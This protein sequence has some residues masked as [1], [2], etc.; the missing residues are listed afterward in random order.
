MNLKNAIDYEKQL[1]HVLSPLCL[2]N[3]PWLWWRHLMGTFS[4]LLALCAG[5]HRSPINSPLKGQWCGALMLSLICAW[6]NGWVNNREAGDLRR[7][8]A[9][10]DVTVMPSQARTHTVYPM[11][12]ALFVVFC[13]YDSFE[14]CYYFTHMRQGLLHH[15]W[16]IA[17]PVSV[18]ESYLTKT[19]GNKA[20]TMG[21]IPELFIVNIFSMAPK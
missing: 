11:T 7:H 9:H 1:T 15:H 3:D 20:K 5:I 8:G 4:A 12:W 2:P 16:G 17:C 14:V 18:N 13:L 19:K 10:Y 6:T 21:I